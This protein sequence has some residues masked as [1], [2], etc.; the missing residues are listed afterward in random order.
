MNW[1]GEFETNGVLFTCI[2]ICRELEV[3]FFGTNQG[4]IRAYLWPFVDLSVKPM[5]MHEI[6][7]H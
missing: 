2:Y 7:V 4:A 3:I 5:E 1:I 6:S